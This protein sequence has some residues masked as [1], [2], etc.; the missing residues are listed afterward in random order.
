MDILIMGRRALV[1]AAAVAML[2]GCGVATTPA[3]MPQAAALFGAPV[4]GG[5]ALIQRPDTAKSWLP[6]IAKKMPHLLYVGDQYT[7]SVFVYE[8]KTGAELGKLTNFKL[9]F[10]LCVD[11]AGD[12][13]VTQ[14]YG[15]SVTEYAHGEAKPIQTLSTG[16]SAIGCAVSPTGDLAV[17]NYGNP[18]RS[19]SVVI[20]T[21]ATGKPVPYTNTKAWYPWGPAYD[22]NG[23]LYVEAENSGFQPSV[24][25]LA[26]GGKSLNS[27]NFLQHINEAASAMWDGRFIEL[28]DQM[29]PGNTTELYQVIASPTGGLSITGSTS[30][31]DSCGEA[32]IAQ[33]FVVGK[34]NTPINIQQGT[35]VVGGNDDCEGNFDYWSYPAGGSPFKTIVMKTLEFAPAK[36]NTQVWGQAVS[37]TIK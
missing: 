31:K 2:A 34:S 5:A 1:L 10:G 28:T 16:G 24:F 13:W 6:A 19:G 33:P 12:V 3:G 26:S 8:Y 35:A 14:Y 27:V 4:P 11:A 32:G 29:Y 25:E 22:S 15:Q 21:H 7:D 23:N 37:N 36:Q 17:S 30:L 18:S 9:P 20:F